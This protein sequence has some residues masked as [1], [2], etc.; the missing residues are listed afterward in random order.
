MVAGQTGQA[1]RPLVEGAFLQRAQTPA[2][3]VVIGPRPA[4]FTALIR[5]QSVPIRPSIRF[6]QRLDRAA[7]STEHIANK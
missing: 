4:M 2:D 5:H 1:Q 7:E 6:P 3:M